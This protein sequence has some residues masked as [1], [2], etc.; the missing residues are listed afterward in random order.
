[1]REKLRK[2]ASWGV[3]PPNFCSQ[4]GSKLPGLRIIRDIRVQHGSARLKT[5][6]ERGRVPP[7]GPVNHSCTFLLQAC[8][9]LLQKGASDVD[10]VIWNYDSHIQL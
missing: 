2:L 5:A 8:I 9:K 4:H 10:W 7:A 1:M 6:G 3:T